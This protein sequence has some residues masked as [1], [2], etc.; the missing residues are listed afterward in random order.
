VASAAELSQLS[1]KA[2]AG[3][4]ALEVQRGDKTRQLEIDAQAPNTEVRSALRPDYD[5]A[6]PALNATAPARGYYNNGYAP[7]RG[8]FRG[9]R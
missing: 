3:P 6:A 8:L 7:R 2:A 1:A 9:R 5:N 4:I